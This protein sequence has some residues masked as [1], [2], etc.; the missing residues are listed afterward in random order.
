MSRY[1][2]MERICKELSDRVYELNGRVRILEDRET[3]IC[4]RLLDAEEMIE[5]LGNAFT[6]RR[7][8]RRNND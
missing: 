4:K 8:E 2:D 3:K 1:D 6:K 7:I 5:Q